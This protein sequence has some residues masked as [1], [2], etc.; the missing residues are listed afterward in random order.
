MSSYRLILATPLARGAYLRLAD[1]RE[2]HAARRKRREGSG[3][4]R[5]GS[6]SDQEDHARE[7]GNARRASDFPA[8][9]A[10]GKRAA[11]VPALACLSKWVA[12]MRVTARVVRAAR[13]RCA[14]LRATTGMAAAT[15]RVADILSAV[16][17]TLT[18]EARR[19]WRTP[20]CRSSYLFSHFSP[21]LAVWHSPVCQF[22]V[23]IQVTDG[24]PGPGGSTG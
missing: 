9:P 1:G 13:L 7:G 12:C 16:W 5:G 22:S 3:E 6:G 4:E 18:G 23:K 19:K 11:T 21:S 17:L 2:L 14:A 8:D 20:P 15:A 10:P 24:P